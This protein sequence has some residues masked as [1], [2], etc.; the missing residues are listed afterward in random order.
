MRDGRITTRKTASAVRSR[1]IFAR[2]HSNF[3]TAAKKTS[4]ESACA[5]RSALLVNCRDLD[6]L[7]A[8]QRLPFLSCKR[9][10]AV[11]TKMTTT[12]NGG[13]FDGETHACERLHITRARTRQLS[14][15]CKRKFLSKTRDSRA[16]K[17][18]DEARRKNNKTKK[19]Q[20]G[21]ANII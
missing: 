1:R 12:I 8:R 5:A 4:Y 20:Y 16:Q 18:D 7:Q 15:C 21:R 13:I 14:V 10:R 2:R 3:L 19:P 17:P 6:F 9:A 11:W